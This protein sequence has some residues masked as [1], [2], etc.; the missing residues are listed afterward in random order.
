MRVFSTFEE[1]EAAV[2][3]EIGASEWVEITRSGS[4]S[5]PRRPATTSG[6][7][8][9]S[10]GRADGP[11]GGTI[12][13]GY[14]TLSLVP[15]LGSQVVRASRPPGAKLNYGVNKVRFPHPVP[16]ASQDPRPRDHRRGRGH[17]RGQAADRRST[18]SRSR[19]RTSR[20]ASPRPS[21]CCLGLEA[22]TASSAA[23]S[24]VTGRHHRSTRDPA[25]RRLRRYAGRRR[26]R[27]SRPPATPAPA[28]T[29]P[30]SSVC[31]VSSGWPAATSSPGRACSSTPAPA[32]TASPCG[33][34]PAPSRQ[35]ASP[36]AIASRRVSTPDDGAGTTCVSR[37]GGQRRRRGRRPGREI[38]RRQAS[39]AAAV[40]QPVRGVDVVD[41]RRRPASPGPGRGSARRRR[42]GRRRRGPRPTRGPP[43]RCRR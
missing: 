5:S 21:S 6:S 38:I 17:P 23:S 35:A 29:A 27:R 22:W 30:G 3:E 37:A 7:T 40:G 25:S 12:A 31:S 11:F 4:T 16:V 1:L 14:L 43:A 39:I 34:R 24:G 42:P 15:W 33:R 2:G 18:S 36:T 9:T 26:R 28:R 41:A 19:A 10:S 8:S 13:H 20:P 32:C